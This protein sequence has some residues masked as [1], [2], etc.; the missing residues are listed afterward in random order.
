MIFKCNYPELHETAL[1]KI[2][3]CDVINKIKRTE[4]NFTL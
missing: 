1:R 3:K 2:T 4:Y